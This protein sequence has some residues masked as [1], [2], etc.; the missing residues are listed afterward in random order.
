VPVTVIVG[1]DGSLDAVEVRPGD[2]LV[3]DKNGVMCVPKV[4][5]ERAVDL[6]EKN[7]EGDSRYVED[8][9]R[10]VGVAERRVY[11]VLPHRCT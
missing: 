10:G 2:I 8:I 11:F 1:V 9:S 4:L 3:V 5:E 6:A 7:E